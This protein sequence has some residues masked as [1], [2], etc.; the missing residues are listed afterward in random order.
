MSVMIK[1]TNWVVQ[2]PLTSRT[3]LVILNTPSTITLHIFLDTVG[4]IIL[5]SIDAVT[6]TVNSEFTCLICC[7][8]MKMLKQREIKVT[9]SQIWYPI[10]CHLLNLYFWHHTISNRFVFHMTSLMQPWPQ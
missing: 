8:V 5:L 4:I 10:Y 2:L 6:K 3:V 7:S 1:Y 9:N